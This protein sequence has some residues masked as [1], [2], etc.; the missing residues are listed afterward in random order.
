MLVFQEL[1]YVMTDASCTVADDGPCT[2]TDGICE[3]IP[4]P[5]PTCA[6]KTGVYMTYANCNYY[7]ATCSV[8]LTGSACIDENF[9]CIEYSTQDNCRRKL[10]GDYCKW[11]PFANSGAG[12]CAD[13]A[14]VVCA[15]IIA[16][17]GLSY[18]VC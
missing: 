9:A 12:G 5:P 8:N 7:L 15:D 14:T 13:E 18:A 11:D 4:P 17:N 10:G 3:L 2:W 1:F 6:E 16:A